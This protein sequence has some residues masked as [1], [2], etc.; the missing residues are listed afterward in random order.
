MKAILE[1]EITIQK[2]IVTDDEGNSYDVTR[3]PDKLYD[4]STGD[5]FPEFVIQDDDGYEVVLDRQV[6]LDVVAAVKY[7][8]PSKVC[9]QTIVYPFT[10]FTKY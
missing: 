3:Y 6:Y 1:D 5:Y 8:S 9:N 10:Q 7:I 2:F 4:L